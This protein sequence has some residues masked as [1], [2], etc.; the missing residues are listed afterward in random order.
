MPSRPPELIGEISSC[1]LMYT[2]KLFKPRLGKPN[3]DGPHIL[4]LGKAEATKKILYFT[5]YSMEDTEKNRVDHRNEGISQT[6]C[7]S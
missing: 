3:Q 2:S 4:R 7:R 1:R 5:S 6:L